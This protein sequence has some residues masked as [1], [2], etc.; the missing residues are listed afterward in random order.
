MSKSI[1][2]PGFELPPSETWILDH[3]TKQP[4]NNCYAR[5][6]FLWRIPPK[7]EH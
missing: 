1:T 2:S 5:L 6:D 4:L 7:F 3:C